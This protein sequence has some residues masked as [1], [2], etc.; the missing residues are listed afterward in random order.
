MWAERGRIPSRLC[1]VS[2]EPEVQLDPKNREIMISAEI[3]SGTFN[4]LS[5]PGAP[6][7]FIFKFPRTLS[8]VPCEQVFISSVQ[9][10][11]EVFLGIWFSN[12][13]KKLTYK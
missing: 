12:K 7:L 10:L 6:I 3:K 11:S 9:F 2:T 1:I 13:K 4:R 8:P 5:H